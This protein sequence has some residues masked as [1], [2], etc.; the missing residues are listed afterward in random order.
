MKKKLLITVG[1]SVT[2]GWG[3]FDTSSF[4]YIPNKKYFEYTDYGKII[5]KNRKNFHNNSW[6]VKLQKKIKYD[7]LINLGLGGSS[8]SGQL[9]MFVEKFYNTDL[10]KKYDV[11]V[12]WL[13]THEARISFYSNYMNKD[14]LPHIS[15]ET[16]KVKKFSNEYVEIGQAYINFVNDITYDSLLEQSFYVKLMDIMCKQKGFNFLFTAMETKQNKKF[17]EIFS[18]VFPV[19][20]N[21]YILDNLDIIPKVNEKEKWSLLA[22]G[23]PNELGYEHISNAFYNL[24]VKHKN[25]LINN[26][27]PKKYENIFD[28]KY[29]Y[30]KKN[31]V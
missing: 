28:G 19:E 15:N 11:L 2:E 22:C 5:E 4:N 10:S 27:N 25:Y 3:C 26:T 31:I 9:K 30:H 13:L 18:E 7:K 16:Q 1:C 24:I 12:I 14:V 20:S 8:T 29:K 17:V 23:H 6:P 21:L